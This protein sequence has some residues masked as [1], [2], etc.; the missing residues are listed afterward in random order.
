MLIY[1]LLGCNVGNCLETFKQAEVEL[2]NRIGV[3]TQKSGVYLTDAWGNTEQA[4]FLNQVLVLN[5]QLSARECLVQL[6][7]IETQLGR[8]R[9]EKW[10]PRTIDIDIL[11][12]E[13]LILNENDLIIPH[14]FLHE[15]KFALAPLAEIA[16]KLMHPILKK[17]ITQLLS[18]IANNPLKVKRLEP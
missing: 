15:R 8:T 12:Y 4:P 13:N 1:L 11:L 18:D 6:L 17:S 5:T 3:A 2:Q 10:E 14:P 7:A 9:I 16:P